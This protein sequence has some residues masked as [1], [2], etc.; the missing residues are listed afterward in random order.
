MDQLGKMNLLKKYFLFDVRYFCINTIS[1]LE[2]KYSK[3]NNFLKQT[4]KKDLLVGTTQQL[5]SLQKTTYDKGNTC[6]C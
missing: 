2:I 1:F 6:N 3:G 5:K 4:W